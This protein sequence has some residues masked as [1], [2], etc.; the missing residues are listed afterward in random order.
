MSGRRNE[1]SWNDCVAFIEVA[2]K[3]S[4]NILQHEK[5]CEEV[6]D[7]FLSRFNYGPQSEKATEITKVLTTFYMEVV[8]RNKIV[9]LGA[10]KARELAMTRLGRIIHA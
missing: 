8:E 6:I 7:I 4:R 9:W 3:R 1:L 2:A 10:G 5:A